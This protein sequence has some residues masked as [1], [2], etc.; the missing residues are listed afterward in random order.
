MPDHTSSLGAAPDLAA[1]RAVMALC[2]EARAEELRAALAEIGAADEP[3]DL[4][5]PETGLVMTRGR[6]GGDG[7]PFNLGE[8]TVT[9]AAVRLPGGETGFAYHLGRDRAKARLAA[10]LD[11][12]WQRPERREAVEAALAPVAARRA[13][14]R[15]AEARR[16]AATRVNFFT[17]ARGED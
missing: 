11:A 8:A 5:A 9:R 13:E 7:R 16:I 12:F 3:E 6:I 15:A 10:T 14:E 17:M 2:G 4:R 1:R